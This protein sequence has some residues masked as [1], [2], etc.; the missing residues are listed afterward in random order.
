MIKL[1]KINEINTEGEEGKILMMAIAIVE[2][3]K[4]LLRV[5]TSIN[6]EDIRER[7]WG[8]MTHPDD[9]IKRVVELTNKVYYEKEWKLEQGRIIRDNKINSIMD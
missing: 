8:G 7:K 3:S 4:G 2:L 1:Q 9:A 5:L 6:E